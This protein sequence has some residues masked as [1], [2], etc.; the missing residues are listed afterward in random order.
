[1]GFEARWDHHGRG[2]WKR[3]QRADTWGLWYL[4]VREWRENQQRRV[5]RF[6]QGYRRAVGVLQV[7]GRNCFKE[8]E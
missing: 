7:S 2:S 4:L 5:E 1:M 6:S 3:R 8:E